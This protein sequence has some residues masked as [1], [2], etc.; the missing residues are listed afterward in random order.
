MTEKAFI[1]QNL[2]GLDGNDEEA[3]NGNGEEDGSSFRTWHWRRKYMIWMISTSEKKSN[4][5]EMKRLH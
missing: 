3:T 2:S 1:F 5:N 4:Y